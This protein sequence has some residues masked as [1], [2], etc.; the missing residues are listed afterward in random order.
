[1]NA[2]TALCPVILAGGRGSR[3]WPLSRQHYPKQFIRFFGKHSLLQETLLR[4]VGMRSNRVLPP[5]IVCSEAYRFTIGRQVTEI[6][7]PVQ[8]LILE[9]VGRNTAPALTLAALALLELGEDSVVL[10]LPADHTIKKQ[11]AFYQALETGFSLAEDNFMVVFGIQPVRPETGYGYIR[12]GK[13]LPV[14]DTAYAMQVSDFKE[15]PPQTLAR[16]YLHSHKSLWNSGMYM[17]RASAWLA[18]ISE[19]QPEIYR[20]CVT[21]HETR[22]QG[23]NFYR[24]SEQ[25]FTGCPSISVDHAIMEKLTSTVT[26][27]AAVIPLNAGWSDVGAWSEVW[28]YSAK[29][30]HNNVTAGDV[31]AMATTNS[32]IHA[33]GRLVGVQGCD[34]LAIIETA[35]AVMVLN[36][37][38]AQDIRQLVVELGDKKREEL[39]RHSCVSSP[40]GEYEIIG[41]GAGYQVKR[42]GILPRQRLSLQL[43]HRRSEHWV[44]TR[45]TATVTR[46]K[47]VFDLKANTSTFIPMGVKHRLENRTDSTLE[48]I[49]VQLGEYLGEDDI[50]RF[51]DDYNR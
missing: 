28:E 31:I 8:P 23:D 15:K 4:C 1:M 21:T 42:L 22:M 44:V 16:E 36:K 30:E 29:D 25:S 47:D 5:L 43:H 39:C 51:D 40:W 33:S 35:D 11:A 6:D 10:M 32:L 41:G 18:M 48:L 27:K 13:K 12:C 34:N 3:L 7:I 46:D 14:S 49:E 2:V 38:R 26:T 45:G 20:V 50:V 24:L 17:V 37:D 9:P 19:A